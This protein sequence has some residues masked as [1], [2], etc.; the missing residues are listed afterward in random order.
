METADRPSEDTGILIRL[1]KL[2][3]DCMHEATVAIDPMSEGNGTH[4]E[5][6]MEKETQKE[7]MHDKKQK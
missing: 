3:H 7:K 1:N 4:N 6:E 2:L 5:G